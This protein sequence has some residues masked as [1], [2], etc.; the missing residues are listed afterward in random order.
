M[1]YKSDNEI[2]QIHSSTTFYMKEHLF[3]KT[4]TDD[5]KYFQQTITISSWNERK[6]PQIYSTRAI[7][8]MKSDY[9]VSFLPRLSLN[10]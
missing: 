6:S 2:H 3:A 10:R 4:K 9:V 7:K 1:M 8:V 5:A